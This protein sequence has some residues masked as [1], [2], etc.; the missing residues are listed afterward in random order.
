MRV[1]FTSPHP[2]DFPPDVLEAIATRPNICNSIH[3]PVQSGSSSVLQRMRRGYSREAYLGLVSQ[4]RSLIPNVS[5]ST[6]LISGF[7][8]ET[9][10]EH[11]DT[12]SLL[13]EVR[14]DQAF[15]YAYSL[16]D[17]THAA[18]TMM[19]NV[20][21][22]VKKRRL[23]EV[24]DTY[25]EVLLKKNIE[26]EHGQ[27]RLVLVE[28]ESTKSTPENLMYT[29]RTEGNKRVVFPATDLIPAA[30]M[31]TYLGLNSPIFSEIDSIST[32]DKMNLLNFGL[33]SSE[34][35]FCG[36]MADYKIAQMAGCVPKQDL[37]GQYVAVRI[38]KSDTPTMRGVAF[39]LS[40]VKDF[41]E[42]TNQTQKK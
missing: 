32:E 15:M 10:E 24:I 2:K 30:S 8:D 40:T 7:C 17:R 18:H 29:G 25:R 9:E 28:E 14:Y 1:R 37:I 6:D 23:Q 13:R 4:I 26:E 20:P 42:F 27:W 31:L 36:P 39:G 22:D 35:K 19:D 41:Q 11:Q 21:E 33:F 38:L 5:I 12:L 34:N 3:L 16:R